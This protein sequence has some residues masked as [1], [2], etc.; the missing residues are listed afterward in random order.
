DL[1]TAEINQGAAMQLAVCPTKIA[2]YC[3]MNPQQFF[4][5]DYAAG[6]IVAS[7]S[8]PIDQYGITKQIN[9]LNVNNTIFA[10]A[11]KVLFAGLISLTGADNIGLYDIDNPELFYSHISTGE[12][13]LSARADASTIARFDIGGNVIQSIQPEEIPYDSPRYVYASHESDDSY[14]LVGLTAENQAFIM[15]VDTSGKLISF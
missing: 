11:E 2:A 14:L 1:A 15:R 4:M 10:V 13:I 5:L 7:Q 8:Q 12:L 9:L 3:D 6:E